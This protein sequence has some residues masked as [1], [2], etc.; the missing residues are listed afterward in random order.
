M[1][2]AQRAAADS[3]GW[4]PA[5]DGQ[6]S[7]R[8]ERFWP[9]TVF[10]YFVNTVDLVWFANYFANFPISVCLAN[11]FVNTPLEELKEI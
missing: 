8:S 5:H 1:S 10:T 3:S 7:E 2:R 11:Y 4:N 9:S 6:K